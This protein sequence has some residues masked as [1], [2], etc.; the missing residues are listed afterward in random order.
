M[1]GCEDGTDSVAPPLEET[2]NDSEPSLEDE[3]AS[4]Q[5]VEETPKNWK[6]NWEP[7]EPVL[8]RLTRSQYGNVLQ[9]I[10]GDKLVIPTSLEPDSRSHGLMAVGASINGLSPVGVEKYFSAAKAVSKQVINQAELRSMHLECAEG[11]DVADAACLNEL[12]D[13]YGRQL[14]RR[15]LTQGEKDELLT[16]A[17][18]A[19]EAMTTALPGIETLLTGLLLSPHFLYIMTPTLPG[20]ERTLYSGQAMASRISFFLWNSAPD[21]ELLT[22]AE[23]GLLDSP[24]GLEEQVARMITDPRTRRGMRAFFTDWWELDLLDGLLKDPKTFPHFYAKL[25]M[26]AREETLRF[27]EEIVFDNPTDIRNLYTST[28][29]FVNPPLASIYQIPSPTIEGFGQVELDPNAERAGVLGQVS[30]LATQAHPTRPSPTLRG[31]FVR[32]KLLCLSMPPPPANVDTTVPETSLDA[33]TIKEI[34]EVHMKEPSCAVCH[35]MTDPIGLGFE[36]F[37]G[38]GRYRLLENGVPIDPTGSLDKIDFE[39]ARGLGRAV[40]EHSRSVP[41]VVSTAWIY[42]NGRGLSSDDNHVL[43]DLEI[44]FEESGYQL[45]SLLAEIAVH[46][47]FLETREGQ[48]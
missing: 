9:D 15:P 27:M 40:A 22:A 19:Q 10:F 36:R 7:A 25:G 8:R 1:L 44:R 26:D 4:S 3:D 13:T 6:D 32:E 33:P 28:T 48:P 24:E 30:F 21:E 46:P 43:K 11:A 34:L 14:W 41:C 38:I 35:A 2:T 29:T 23:E 31:V 5:S 37:D 12:L 16:L 17:V 42:A 47:A 20:E 45:L 39:D 18:E